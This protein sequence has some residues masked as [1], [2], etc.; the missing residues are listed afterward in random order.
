VSETVLRC[1]GLSKSFSSGGGTIRAF[2]DVEVSVGLGEIA[3]VMGRSGSGKTTLLQVL[4]GLDRPSSGTVHICGKDIGAMGEA[5]RTAMRRRNVGFIFQKSNLIPSL[6]ALQNVEASFAGA[7]VA[8]SA[9]R[10][11]AE[12]ILAKLGL[13]ER[14]GHLPVELSEGQRQRVAIARALVRSPHLVFA[15][16]P[17]GDVDAETAGGIM[18]C[19]TTLVREC[20][21]ALVICTHGADPIRTD[22]AFTVRRVCL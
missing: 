6:T 16:E 19:L 11:A 9:R 10:R 21:T 4:A 14:T 15:D 17:T 22:W 8:K 13:A 1:E 12:G 2:A 3:L 7:G 20:G 5:A 18:A